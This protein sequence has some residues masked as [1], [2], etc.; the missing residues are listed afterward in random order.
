VRQMTI[1]VLGLFMLI[2]AFRLVVMVW[3]KHRI[4]QRA[5]MQ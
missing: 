2:V 1:A 3:Q 5:R 4:A